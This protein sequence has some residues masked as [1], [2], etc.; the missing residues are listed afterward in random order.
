MSASWSHDQEPIETENGVSSRLIGVN[1]EMDNGETLFTLLQDAVEAPRALL[2]AEEAAVVAASLE[3]EEVP[4][5]A[6]ENEVGV[7]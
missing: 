7:V 1:A 6:L 4:E 3:D 5:Q 2:E